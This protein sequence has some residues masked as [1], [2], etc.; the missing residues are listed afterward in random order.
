MC[1]PSLTEI[2]QIFL[3]K[4]WVEKLKVKNEVFSHWEYVTIILKF[5]M[6]GKRGDLFKLK[7]RV[8]F[9]RPNTFFSFTGKS[10]S[11]SRHVCCGQHINTQQR[12][13]GCFP[14]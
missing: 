10:I 1:F 9:F 13:G 8:F 2:M 7:K 11:A 3:G 6:K 12:E 14:S 4:K 5:L